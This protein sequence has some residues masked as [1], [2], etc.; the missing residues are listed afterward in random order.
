MRHCV[1]AIGLS[2]AMLLAS[3]GLADA[4]SIQSGLQVGDSLTPFDV[5]NCN[6]P[7]AGETNCQ[8]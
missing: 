4:G 8:V 3:A 1:S 5:L 7:A 2:M 6:G